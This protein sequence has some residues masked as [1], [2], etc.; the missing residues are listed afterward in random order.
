[1]V[2]SGMKSATLIVSTP[3]KEATI[4]IQ[5]IDMLA[6]EDAVECAKA[7]KLLTLHL[8]RSVVSATNGIPVALIDS[9]IR[10]NDFAA[11]FDS[12]DRS[13]E[14]NLF[15]L[16]VALFDE[17]DLRLPDD[18]PEELVLR[19]SEV[20]RKLALSRWLED[21]VAPA[22]DA[23]LTTAAS[24]PAKVFT[25]LTGNQVDRA[26]QSAIE[27][28]DLRLATLLAQIG[29][30]DNFRNEVQRQLNDWQHY[31]S[32]SLIS[33]EYRRIYALLA[34]IT[35]L[36]PGDTARSIE[37][38]ADV[39]VSQG[40]DWKRALG[41]RMWYADRF[42]DDISTVMDSYSAALQDKQHHAD[43]LPAK[44]IPEYLEMGNSRSEKRWK[45]VSEPSDILYG[46]I[47]LYADNTI[48]LEEVLN[49]SDASASP[50]DVRL[51]W[52]LYMLLSKVLQKRD[53]ADRIDLEGGR[54][55]AK[56]DALTQA[57]AAQLERVG[58]WLDAAFVL[59]HLETGQ[60]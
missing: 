2:L 49:P 20:R 12:G 55:S 21:A 28:N 33:P 57:Y 19:I 46:L 50:A 16:G 45:T 23:E 4:T 5:P 48:S 11:R 37:G 8:E 10:F 32:T 14:A 17:I 3:S 22:V 54:Y 34:G 24:R 51:L 30:P 59:L 60:G 40:L 38:C 29:G 25:L 7:D 13:H 26:V 44:P 1:M 35:D 58:S 52:H 18:S 41:V 56:A 36:S 43:A 15:R 9:D 47:R 39:K 53:F 42:E 6:A 27:G 31:K